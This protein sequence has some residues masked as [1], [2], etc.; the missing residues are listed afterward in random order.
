[1]KLLGNIAFK[2]G[3]IKLFSTVAIMNGIVPLS[4]PTVMELEITP[5]L[6]CVITDII[7]LVL[8]FTGYEGL[9]VK[10]GKWGNIGIGAITGSMVG[11]IIGAS[12]GGLVAFG[13]WVIVE[14]FCRYIE[15]TLSN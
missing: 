9:C 2:Q 6:A 8:K 14:A 11:G 1:M 15:K 3:V 10:F 12:I 7:E 13:I 5:F 4:L